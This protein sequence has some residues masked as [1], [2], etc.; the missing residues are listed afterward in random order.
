MLELSDVCVTLPA[1]G[2][3]HRVL[4]HVCLDVAPG[5]RVALVGANGSGKSTIACVCNGALVPNGGG[6]SVDGVGGLSRDELARLVGRVR[7]DPQSQIVSSVVWDEVSF[8]P[9]NLGWAHDRVESAVGEAL[10][11]CNIAHLAGRSTASL[12]GGEAQRVALAGVLAMH[13]SYLVLDEALAQ[14]DPG[15][16]R[17]VRGIVRALLSHGVGVLDI[18]HLEEDALSADR[19]VVLDAGRVVW[20][21]RPW[22]L[23]AS[24]SVVRLSGLQ[25]GRLRALEALG[26]PSLG[27]DAPWP[28]DAGKLALMASEGGLERELSDACLLVQGEPKAAGKGARGLSLD[29]VTVS[30]EAEKPALASATLRV[31]P[32]HVCLVVGPSGSGKSTL[33]LAASGLVGPDSGAVTLDGS[34]VRPGDV[35]LAFQRPENQLFCATALEDV[36]FGP[37]NRGQ[38]RE[39]A[40]AKARDALGLLGVGPDLWDRA[41]LSLSGGERRRVALAGVVAMGQAAFVFDEPTAGLDGP[42]RSLMRNLVRRL[43]ERG[44]AILVVTHDVGEWLPVAT[45]GCLLRAGSVAWSGPACGLLDPATYERAGMEPPFEAQLWEA[46]HG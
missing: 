33:A 10:Q 7:Q 21:G 26:W 6:V 11:E 22:E 18:T 5:E 15:A 38:S 14:L 36:A 40:L 29:G 28:P 2:N 42:S 1:G 9:R 17:G 23:A 31:E 8:G 46:L 37:L 39:W 44:A 19:V 16:R 34:P 25:G 32:G 4:D 20:E 3:R 24:G 30:Y 13:P 45:D 12:S 35:G 43:A 27:A 41:P